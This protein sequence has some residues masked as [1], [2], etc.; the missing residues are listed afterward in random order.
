MVF[1]L[2]SGSLTHFLLLPLCTR[3]LFFFF[4]FLV[5]YCVFVGLMLFLSLQG[6]FS[7]V[8]LLGEIVS[9]LIVRISLS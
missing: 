1:L 2:I 5:M 7:F 8:W 6:C 9:M 4:F 3:I